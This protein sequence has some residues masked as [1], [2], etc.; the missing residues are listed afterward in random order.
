MK[1]IG[2]LVFPDFE[3]LDLYGP[4]EMFAFLGDKVEILVVGQN[5]GVVPAKGGPKTQCDLSYDDDAAFDMLLIP[6]GAGTRQEVTNPATLNWVRSQAEKAE[7]VMTV[8]TGSTLLSA[9]GLLDGHR[10]TTNKRAFEWA[11]SLGPN[12]DWV[13]KARWVE[14]GKYF[15]SSGV[16]AGMDMALEVIAQQFGMEA[17]ETTAISAEYDWH[18]D[19][20]HDP[21]AEIHGLV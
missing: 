4:L 17:A 13:K 5:G 16:S 10:A 18:K 1:K 14:D 7:L 3:L 9:T 20:N 8:C 11:T 19:A 2:A 6:G 12:V 21:F 15:T